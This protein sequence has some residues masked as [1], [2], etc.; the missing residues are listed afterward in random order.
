[1]PLQ[2]EKD[3]N[4]MGK[5]TTEKEINTPIYVLAKQSN[6][7]GDRYIQIMLAVTVWTICRGQ[8]IAGCLNSAAIQKCDAT[9]F[10]S[11][12]KTIYG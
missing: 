4:R 9:L 6:I 5:V 11:R 8:L 3:Q 10:D 12:L 7:K 1:L 2:K